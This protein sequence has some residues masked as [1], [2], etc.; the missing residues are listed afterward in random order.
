M[1]YVDGRDLQ[2]HRRRRGR[3]CSTTQAANYIRQAAVGLGPRPRG[4]ADPSRHQAGQ[5]AGRSQG[6]GQDPRHGLAKFSNDDKASLTI[7]HDEKVLGTADYLAPEQALDSHTVDGRADIYS[8]G[9]TLYFVLTGHPPFPEGTCTQRLMMHQTQQPESIRKQRPEVPEDLVAIF[10]RMTAKKR[11]HRYQKADDVVEALTR[12]LAG[13]RW[14]SAHRYS[15]EAARHRA[16]RG[17]GWAIWRAV[18]PVSRR[19]PGRD[20][21]RRADARP[22]G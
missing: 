4:R 9:C 1:E 11:E 12:W 16:A 17:R 2:V 5:P 10:N 20:R 14:P 19:P 22:P 7:A 18:P 8:L 6:N 15:A 13:T 21:R 3:P